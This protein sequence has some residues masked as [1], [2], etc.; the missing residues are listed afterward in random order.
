MLLI[1]TK[2]KR[3]KHFLR[4][5]APILFWMGLIFYFSSLEGNGYKGNPDFWF[6]AERKG[7]HV[8]EY[9]ILTLLIARALLVKMKKKKEFFQKII[10]VGGLSFLYAISDEIHQIFVYGR[11]GKILDVGIDF[12]GILIAILIL[13]KFYKTKFINNFLAYMQKRFCKKRRK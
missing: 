1:M 12:I 7:A 4:Y 2:N 13:L 5:Y 9:I 6:Y 8:F 11:E 3:T 10:L